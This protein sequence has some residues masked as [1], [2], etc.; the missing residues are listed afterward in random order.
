MSKRTTT[1]TR[2]Q[3]AVWAERKRDFLMIS[4]FGMWATILGLSPVVLFRALS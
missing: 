4:A 3:V 2:N 1:P